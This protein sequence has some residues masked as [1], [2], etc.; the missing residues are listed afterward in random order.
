MDTSLTLLNPGSEDYLDEVEFACQRLGIPKSHGDEEDFPF[1][2][3]P[4]AGGLLPIGI[5]ETN[6]RLCW[7]AVGDAPEWPIVVFWQRGPDGNR[8][9]QIQ[10]TDLLVRLLREEI[11]VECWR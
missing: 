1:P 11:D 5:D 3:F 6:V 2:V 8:V 4:E 9:L 7:Q 10:F